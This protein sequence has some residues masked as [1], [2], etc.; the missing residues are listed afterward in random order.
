M[1]ISFSA[2]PED[3]DK[4]PE[5]YK[6]I[7]GYSNAS[8]NIVSTF[9]KNGFK[10]TTNDP[11]APVAIGVGYP[12]DY[13]FY[14]HQYKIGYTAWESTEL[15]DGWDEIMHGCDEIWATSSWTARVF[16]KQLGIDNVHVYPHG[17]NSDWSL[18]EREVRK[19][20]RFLHIGEPQIRKNAQLV[21]DAFSELFGKDPNYQL[22]LKCTGINSTRVYA[23]DGSIIGSPDAYYTN[24]KILTDEFSHKQMLDLYH[25]SHALVYPTAGEGFGFIPLQA[26]ATGM[27]TISTWQ[28]AEYK[29]FITI[30][31]KS[32]LSESIH[33]ELHPGLTYHVEKEVLKQSMIDMVENYDKYQSQAVKNSSKIH[34]L[35]NWDKV[36]EPTIKK[37]K[38][39][40]KTR[41]L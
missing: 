26:L 25:L 16:K 19:V 11:L 17:I 37:L 15:K 14:P 1:I 9:K 13:N 27:P 20:F 8:S 24:I 32:S 39:I 28:W 33:D 41:G 21:V 23:K 34:E 40:F 7:V 5:E 31:L 12:T 10:W 18:K 36:S 30:K 4:I 38:N 2:A 3:L 35:Y 29:D 6:D 22:I